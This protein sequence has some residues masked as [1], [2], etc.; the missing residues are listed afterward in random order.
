MDP[1]DIAKVIA[2][3]RR[4]SKKQART[5]RSQ[6]SLGVGLSRMAAK[7]SCK[8]DVRRPNG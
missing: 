4:Y 3:L 2:D 5:C 8:E 1:S 6:P 7:V